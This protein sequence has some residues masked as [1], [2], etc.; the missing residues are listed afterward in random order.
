MRDFKKT[1][2]TGKDLISR[3]VMEPRRMDYVW[4]LEGDLGKARSMAD[5]YKKFHRLLRNVK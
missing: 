1:G 4:Q 5:I 3:E 2:R